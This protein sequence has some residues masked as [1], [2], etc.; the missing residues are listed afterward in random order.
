MVARKRLTTR[1]PDPIPPVD[2]KG[3]P[4][5]AWSA[6]LAPR[7]SEELDLNGKR[8][9]Q[10]IDPRTLDAE[11]LEKAGHPDRTPTKCVKLYLQSLDRPVSRTDKDQKGLSAVTRLCVDCVG[12]ESSSATVMRTVRACTSIEC[13][14]WVHRFG[15]NPFRQK[16]TGP[17]SK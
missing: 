3:G 15:R 2:G 8:K 5:V 14:L 4:N 7:T 17:N 12:G 9:R 6:I 11:T 13:P 10:G 16:G 1:Q